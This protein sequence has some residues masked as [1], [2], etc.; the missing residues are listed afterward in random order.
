VGAV[1]RKE[2][3]VAEFSRPSYGLNQAI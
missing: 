3:P 2:N 1:P